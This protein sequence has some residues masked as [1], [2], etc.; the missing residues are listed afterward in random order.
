MHG[1][2]DVM[3]VVL[4]NTG[5]ACKK[6]AGLGKAWAQKY[7]STFNHVVLQTSNVKTVFFDNINPWLS[8]KRTIFIRVKQHDPINNTVTFVYAANCSSKTC[9]GVCYIM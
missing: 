7:A 1:L 4:L 5:E 6:L 3:L 9:N 8:C 2:F